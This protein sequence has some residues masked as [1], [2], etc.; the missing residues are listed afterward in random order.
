MRR[1]ILPQ[2]QAS[3]MGSLTRPVSS[4]PTRGQI[5]FGIGCRMLICFSL[6]WDS[7]GFSS[8]VFVSGKLR[9]KRCTSKDPGRSLDGYFQMLP[10]LPMLKTKQ[11][12]CSCRHNDTLCDDN[13]TAYG[14][15]KNCVHFP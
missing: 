11:S 9:Y 12:S 15:K 6:G 8:Y 10:G 1:N 14:V 3:G 5:I 13:L 4:K 7:K 2:T